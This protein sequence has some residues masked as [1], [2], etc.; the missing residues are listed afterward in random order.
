MLKF[1]LSRMI[2]HADVGY[3]QKGEGDYRDVSPVPL[4]SNESHDPSTVKFGRWL[5]A[6]SLH[7][8]MNEHKMI[9]MKV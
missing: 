5:R 4:G 1:Y 6:K 7:S 8:I 2:S 9:E 3:V